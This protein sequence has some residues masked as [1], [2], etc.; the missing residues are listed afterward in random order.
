[1]RS[2]VLCLVLASSVSAQEVKSVFRLYDEFK[3]VRSVQTRILVGQQLGA[4]GGS[5]TL[6]ARE[7]S[8]MREIV[9]ELAKSEHKEL[10]RAACIALGNVGDKTTVAMLSTL[11]DDSEELVRFS[12]LRSVS[13]LRDTAYVPALKKFIED[14]G[15]ARR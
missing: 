13:K 3:S 4:R 12:A 1:M 7:R 6:T 15:A 10:R 11:L 5:P 8:K 2:M 9:P 14:H